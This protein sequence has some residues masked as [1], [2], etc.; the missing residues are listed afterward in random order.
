MTLRIPLDALD[1][2]KSQLSHSPHVTFSE[3]T[4]MP[5]MIPVTKKTGRRWRGEER[6]EGKKAP[7]YLIVN[8]YEHV[9]PLTSIQLSISMSAAGAAAASFLDPML[10]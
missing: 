8:K 7:E 4:N 1:I 5:T 10:Y 3:W 2:F 6:P 9:P